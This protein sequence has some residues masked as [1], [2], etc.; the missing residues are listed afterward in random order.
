[1]STQTL[2]N[3]VKVM[4]F[5]L[6][7]GVLIHAYLFYLARSSS[8]VTIP[9]ALGI[10]VTLVSVLIVAGGLVLGFFGF[11][12][13]ED[14]EQKALA[15]AATAARAAVRELSRNQTARVPQTSQVQPRPADELSLS[16][17]KESGIQ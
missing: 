15:Q 3:V 17:E 2:S 10:Q 7:G 6:L 14:I 12:R 5:V 16:G 4:G 11:S 9:L 8:T 13:L 1:M